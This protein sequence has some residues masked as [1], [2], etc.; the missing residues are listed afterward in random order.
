MIAF[1]RQLK[2]LS[3]VLFWRASEIDL[4]A[5]LGL[6]GI[7]L[8]HL[9]STVTQLRQPS[10]AKL[11]VISPRL[12]VLNNIPFVIPF[13]QRV[14]I[15]R[16]FVRNDR[17]RHALPVRWREEFVTIRRHHVF[18]DGF[19]HLYH[20]GAGLKGRV[21]ISFVDEFN[22]T[23]AGIDGGGVFKEFLTNLGHEAFDTNFGLFLETADNLLYPNPGKS[24]TTPTQLAYYEFLGLIIGKALYEGILLD[25]AFADFFLKKCLGG[26]NYLDDLP[27][28][29][30]GLYN[31]LMAV[32]NF[33]GNFE[34]LALDFTLTRTD[35]GQTQ[36]IDL[37]PNGS[38]TPVTRENCIRY[39]YLVANYRLNVEIAKQSRAFLRGLSTIVDVKWLRMF[40]QAELQ[41]L[42]GGASVPID[43][44]D[45]RKHTVYSGFEGADNNETVQYLWRALESFDNTERQ[46]FL[47]FVTS[48]SRPPLLGFREL[49][50][51]LCV[52]S[53]GE[54]DHRLPTS[55]TCIN[56]LKLPR[57]SSYSILRTKLLYAINAEAGFDLS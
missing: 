28:L 31:G 9:R 16:K 33:R 50:P 48:C 53:A 27:S 32:K 49:Q 24:A 2:N 30:P 39:V 19:T 46:K 36:T 29:D 14:E 1:S 37:V 12:G 13:E 38:H 45:L 15:F 11:A 18:E 57:F 23:E 6:T 44:E 10:K 47:K 20:L 4:E 25:V 34:D 41:I 8:S 55:A 5:P 3:F 26:I 54:D 43:L 42:L 7:R 22:L 21:A 35:N 17:D 51:K 40:N 52:R 56:L